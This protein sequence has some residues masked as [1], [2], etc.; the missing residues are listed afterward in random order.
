[1]MHGC[2]TKEKVAEANRWNQ[3]RTIMVVHEN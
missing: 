3:K 1:M 2:K